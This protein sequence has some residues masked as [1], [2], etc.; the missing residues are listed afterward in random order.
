M[1]NVYQGHFVQGH[2]DAA[3][4]KKLFIIGKSWLLVI[5]LPTKYNKLDLFK[6]DQSL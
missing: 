3:L 6:K 1:A 4:V 5:N 2:V